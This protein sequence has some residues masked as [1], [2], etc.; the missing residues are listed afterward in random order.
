MIYL[1]SPYSHPDPLVCKARFDAACRATADLIRAGKTVFSPIVHGH[2]L[3]HFG[4]ATDWTFWQRCAR[5]YLRWSD[6]VLVLQIDG[7]QESEGVR[8]EMALA[9]ALGKRVDYLEPKNDAISLNFRSSPH[10]APVGHEAHPP[11]DGPVGRTR[12]PTPTSP[13]LGNHVPGRAAPRIGT[14]PC[15]KP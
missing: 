9:S 1:A 12:D 6:E 15:P 13:N 4:L 8:A 11:A 14:L 2:P 7:W 3:V 10:V 5:E